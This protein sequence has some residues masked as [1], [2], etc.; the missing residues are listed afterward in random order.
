MANA[1]QGNNFLEGPLG[2]VNVEFDSVDLGKTTDVTSVEIIED[3][4]DIIYQQTG[5]QPDDKIPT[6]QAYQVNCTFGEIDTALVAALIRGVT[7]S[8]GGNSIAMAPD[9]Y[10]SGK[11]NFAK[12]LILKRVDSAGASSAD[13]HFWMT[14]YAAMP[15]VQGTIDYSSDTQKGLNVIFYCFQD[16]TKNAYGYVGYASSVGLG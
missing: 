15:M 9:L 16:S 13:P 1:P 11:I 2:V 14:F 5:T 6:G 10:R 3:L 7:A 4:L 8:G 12:E